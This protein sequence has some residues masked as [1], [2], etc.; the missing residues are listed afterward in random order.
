VLFVTACSQAPTAAVTP[1]FA[2]TEA[3]VGPNRLPIGL[4][5]NGSPLNDPAATVTATFYDLDVS[6]ETA[7]G[8]STATYYGAGLPAAVYVATYDFPRAGNY[9]VQIDTVVGGQ[10]SQ[11]KLQLTVLERAV[12]PK[13]G[14][15]AISAKTLTSTSVADPVEL[16]SSTQRDP[17][18]YATSLDEA[19][20]AK[21]PIALLFATPGFCRT[22]VCGPS[23]QVFEGL[24]KTYGSDVVF[25]HSEIYRYPFGDSFAKQSEVFQNAMTA[26]RNLNDEERKVGVSDAYYAWGLQSEPWLFL[27]DSAGVIV[28]R[29]EGGLTSE[30]LSPALAALN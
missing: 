30:E 29:Y 26:G 10:T 3:V 27:I 17:A 24:A 12:A 15:L 2:F 13:V 6:K 14:D 20:A 25:I 28:G 21:K 16:S 23:L 9:G 22:A 11:S 4:I 1:V 7:I 18:L 19:L 8:S 5:Q